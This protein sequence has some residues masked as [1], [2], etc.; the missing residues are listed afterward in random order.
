MFDEKRKRKK[1]Q[2]KPTKGIFNQ[3]GSASE[4]HIKNQLS[5]IS[6]FV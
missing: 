5:F 1:D 3:K 2:S 4:N 6:Y